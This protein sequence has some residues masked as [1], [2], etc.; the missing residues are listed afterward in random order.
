MTFGKSIAAF[1]EGIAA[2]SEKAVQN[3]VDSVSK[4]IADG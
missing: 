4:R 2:G 3:I 1:H